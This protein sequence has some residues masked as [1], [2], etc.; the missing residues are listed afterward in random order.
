M[1]HIKWSREKI[2]IKLNRTI[3]AIAVTAALGVS[4][5]ALANNTNGNISGST[6]TANGQELGDVSVT[7][8]T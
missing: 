6:L 7:I 8:K 4:A 1:N 3:A 2:M 5:P